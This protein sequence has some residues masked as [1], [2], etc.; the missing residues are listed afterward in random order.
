[1]GAFSMVT[2]GIMPG[3]QQVKGRFKD[4]VYEEQVTIDYVNG[5]GKQG[6]YQQMLTSMMTDQWNWIKNDRHIRLIDDRNAVCS[7]SMAE[8]ATRMSLEFNY[9]KGH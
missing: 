7:T 4:L 9:T 3:S 2:H 6:L 8:E 1:M 5:N